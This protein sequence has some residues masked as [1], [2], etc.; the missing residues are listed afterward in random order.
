MSIKFY[1]YARKSESLFFNYYDC[2]KTHLR[3]IKKLTKI[4][5]KIVFVIY[6]NILNHD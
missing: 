5:E 6:Y 4:N 1:Y 3:L 2:V